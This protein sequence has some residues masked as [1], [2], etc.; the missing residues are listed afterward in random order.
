[1]DMNDKEFQEKMGEIRYSM[2]FHQE[3][4]P[5]QTFRRGERGVKDLFKRENKR[6]R[7]GLSILPRNLE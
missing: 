7:T 4:N 1:M 2:S 5:F 3:R 6:N